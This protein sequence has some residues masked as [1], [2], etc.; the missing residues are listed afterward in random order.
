RAVVFAGSHGR[1]AGAGASPER[2]SAC[3]CDSTEWAHRSSSATSIGNALVEGPCASSTRR[4]GKSTRAW[5]ANDAEIDRSKLI[6][7]RPSVGGNDPGARGRGHEQV[8][9]MACH[10]PPEIHR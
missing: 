3:A 2:A 6:G 10:D 5:T 9:E 7:P 1:R 8:V 4:H